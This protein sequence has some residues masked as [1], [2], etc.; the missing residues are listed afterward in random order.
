MQPPSG[1]SGEIHRV[2]PCPHRTVVESGE[3]A[4]GVLCCSGGEHD[5]EGR[6]ISDRF[7][8][9]EVKHE[10]RPRLGAGWDQ[11]VPIGFG[12]ELG[13]PSRNEA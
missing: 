2:A 12:V 5:A 6:E 7:R 11:G 4:V 10:C 8:C 13:C 9:R 1:A 3:L